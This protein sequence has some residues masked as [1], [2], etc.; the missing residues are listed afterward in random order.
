MIKRKHIAVAAAF[1]AIAT[2]GAAVVSRSSSGGGIDV[3]VG[4]TPTSTAPSDPCAGEGFTFCD[5]FAGS[6]LDTSRWVAVNSHM[7]LS[8]SEAGCY[9]ADHVTEG[10]GVTTETVEHNT[11]F[12]CP[13][14]T[15]ANAYPSGAIQ[16][17]SFAFLYGTI[18]VHM[19]VAGCGGCWGGLWVL[20]SDCQFPQWL[21]NGGDSP[22]CN[23]PTAGSEEIDIAEF[24][25]DAGYTKV[26]NAA[27]TAAGS[28]AD[29]GTGTITDAS[30]NLH[31][32]TLVWS[33]GSATFKVDGVTQNHFTSDISSSLSFIIINTAIGG[34]GGAINN[35]TLPTTAD[36]DWVHVTVAGPDATVKPSIS[37][38]TVHGS[39]LTASNGTWT[40]SPT[41]FSYR[42]LRCDSNGQ[43]CSVISGATSSTY[44]TT[45]TD[46]GH[47]IQVAVRA[48]N[49]AGATQFGST[50]TA[51]VT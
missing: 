5:E 6:S 11:S 46:V 32:Y 18:D 48:N 49:A 42:W 10:S 24:F 27:I 9:S 45:T 30:A 41:S 34:N 19:R 15:G 21:V 22:N 51:A 14:T 37:G 39:V 26:H 31:T 44:T 47:K 20:G 16:S 25:S 35:A 36:T 33:A 28:T 3:F 17:Q 29:Y 40:G 8:N 50:P 4:S 43:N 1:V 23:W 12:T 38:S 2:A 13:D 7:D